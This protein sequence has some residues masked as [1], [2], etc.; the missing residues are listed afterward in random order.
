MKLRAT[1][2]CSILKQIAKKNVEMK[3]QFLYKI[4]I[5]FFNFSFYGAYNFK[6]VFFLF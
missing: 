3:N 1:I 6:I 2:D 5:S 4:A